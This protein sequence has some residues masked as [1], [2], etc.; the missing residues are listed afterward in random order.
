MD[1]RMYVSVGQ[2]SLPRCIHI[3]LCK[4]KCTWLLEMDP[5]MPKLYEQVL[6]IPFDL[7]CLLWNIVMFNLTTIFMR[8]FLFLGQIYLSKHQRQ[9]IDPQIFIYYL[10]F[11]HAYVHMCVLIKR[12]RLW[13]IWELLGRSFVRSLLWRARPAA[14]LLRFLSKSFVITTTF[15]GMYV[16]CQPAQNF[17]LCVCILGEY[18]Y[19]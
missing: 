5:H 16:Y 3:Y 4:C 19:F 18:H 14:I 11:V 17:D 13:S 8:I 1:V 15:T 9:H 6:V 7:S 2:V 10:F 12:Q